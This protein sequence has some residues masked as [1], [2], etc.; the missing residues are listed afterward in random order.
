[1][2]IYLRKMEIHGRETMDEILKWAQ[3]R[4]MENVRLRLKLRKVSEN[5]FKRR[6]PS[7]WTF[8]YKLKIYF[9]AEK[10]AK[11]P[12]KG[13]TVVPVD[14]LNTFSSAMNELLNAAFIAH[15][16]FNRLPIPSFSIECVMRNPQAKTWRSLFLS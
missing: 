4:G 1:M 10:D 8:K 7:R 2:G 11:F 16:R 14:K 9:L 3:R 5:S 6:S 13:T 12:K 15:I